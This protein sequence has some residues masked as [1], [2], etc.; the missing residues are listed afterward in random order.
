KHQLKFNSHKD[1]KLLMEAIEK[2]FGGN[3]ET[4]K[5][6]KTLLKQ[7]DSRK[8]GAIEPQRR[9]VLVEASTSNALDSQCEGVGIYD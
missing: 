3:I 5:V 6:Q 9:T 7:R 4:K 2:R 8:N 1:A